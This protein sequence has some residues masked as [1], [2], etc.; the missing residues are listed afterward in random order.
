MRKTATKLSKVNVNG[1]RLYC[2]NWPRIGRGRNRR[3]FREKVEAETFLGAKLIE[4][5]NYGT[6]GTSFT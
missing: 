2:V 1:R 5:E 6:A 3:F 4:R